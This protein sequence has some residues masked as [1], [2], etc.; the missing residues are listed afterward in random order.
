MRHF[1]RVHQPIVVA[2]HRLIHPLVFADV[3][4]HRKIEI[5]APPRGSGPSGGIIDVHGK[6]VRIAPLPAQPS[7]FVTE[8]PPTPTAPIGRNAPIRRLP[9]L[10]ILA[11]RIQC[12]QCHTTSQND[13]DTGYT[14]QQRSS[15]AFLSPPDHHDRLLDANRIHVANPLRH[16]Q[17]RFCVSMAVDIDHWEASFSPE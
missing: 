6:G 10:N 11:C 9:A 15:N 7:A 13:L 1:E 2:I 3:D 14:T 5:G 17:W 4:I 12:S 16:Q 8:P